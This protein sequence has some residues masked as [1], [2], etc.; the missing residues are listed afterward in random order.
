MTTLR[1]DEFWEG[2]FFYSISDAHPLLDSLLI[3]TANLATDPKG[4][5][6]FRFFWNSDAQDYIIKPI[7][8]AMCVARLTDI[9]DE[10]STMFARGKRGAEFFRADQDRAGF[11][12]GLTCQP[13]NE[14]LWLQVLLLS[15]F[16]SDPAD[17][18]ILVTK[19]Q[20][21][22]TWAENYVRS[23]GFLNR[24]LYMNYARR[25]GFCR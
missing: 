24:F 8:S 13:I 11:I 14:D 25:D 18:E 10:I 1:L 15:I 4:M 5:S 17:D 12:N 16:W 21:Y 9:S 22:S 7:S 3:S 6:A 2:A 23:S 19:F 20:Q